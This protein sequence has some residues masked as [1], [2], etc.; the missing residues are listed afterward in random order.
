MRVSAIRTEIEEIRDDLG[1]YIS[2]LDRRRHE[3]LDFRLQ[4]RRH[5]DLVLSVG[6]G[7]AAIA[8]ALVAW[9]MRKPREP[10]SLAARINERIDESLTARVKDRVRK[11]DLLDSLGRAMIAVAAAGGVALVKSLVDRRRSRTDEA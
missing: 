7:L 4:L 11:H 6:V 9:R 10:L 8:G 2:E 5:R 3:A 1:T